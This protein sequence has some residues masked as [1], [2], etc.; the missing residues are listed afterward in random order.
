[1]RDVALSV[2]SGRFSFTGICSELSMELDRPNSDRLP[3]NLFRLPAADFEFQHHL[4]R[5][6]FS[7]YVLVDHVQVCLSQLNL[8]HRGNSHRD[9]EYQSNMLIRLS[10]DS[11]IPA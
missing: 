7:L 1:M 10:P 6:T 8:E 11:V 2:A 5:P 4:L 9:R 3:H